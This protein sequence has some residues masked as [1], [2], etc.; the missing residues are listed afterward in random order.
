MEFPNDNDNTTDLQLFVNSLADAVY[1]GRVA[2]HL[3]LNLE[4]SFSQA[5]FH[6]AEIGSCRN[7]EFYFENR[8]GVH[9][10]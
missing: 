2:D 8:P 4:I 6:V 5:L 9:S 1:N 10:V 7:C 3:I